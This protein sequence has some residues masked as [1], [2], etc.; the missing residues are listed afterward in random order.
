MQVSLSELQF[1][2]HGRSCTLWLDPGGELAHLQENLVQ[3]FPDCTDLSHDP[4][5]NIAK[6]SAHL[7]LGQWPSAEAV[8]HAQ[9]VP[10]S[11]LFLQLLRAMT[12]RGLAC[13]AGVCS[14]NYAEGSLDTARLVSFCQLSVLDQLNAVIFML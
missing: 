3:A 2:D 8:R 12:S 14:H 5:R 1:F 4:A 10:A 6:F 13:K 9:K 7:S 11:V